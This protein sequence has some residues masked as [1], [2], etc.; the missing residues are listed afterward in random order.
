[1]NRVVTE[2]T[3]ATMM[4]VLNE[5]A[6]QDSLGLIEKRMKIASAM[7]GCYEGPAGRLTIG[8]SPDNVTLLSV[9][10]NVGGVDVH[11]INVT[12]PKAINALRRLLDHT[13]KP[14]NKMVGG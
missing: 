4:D 12:P 6:A 1:M 13:T 8:R 10:G 14:V 7:Y 3:I 2:D 11:A 9:K 5:I